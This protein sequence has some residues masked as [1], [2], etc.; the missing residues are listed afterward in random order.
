[1]PAH[2][3]GP[4]G[5][6]ETLQPSR[7]GA[8]RPPDFGRH[9]FRAFGGE[10]ISID[11]Q[12]CRV[13]LRHSRRIRYRLLRAVLRTAEAVAWLARPRSRSS[14][15]R[16]ADPRCTRPFRHPLRVLA[17]A[18]IRHVPILTSLTRHQSGTVT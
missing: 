18:A 13:R 10:M 1:M 2:A 8:H 4:H 6:N 12:H 7:V 14:V 5:G 15:A 11:L 16:V 17:L 3:L 9:L